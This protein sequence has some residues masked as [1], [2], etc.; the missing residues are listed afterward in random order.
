[1]NHFFMTF[2]LVQFFLFVLDIFPISGRKIM[3]NTL[4]PFSKIGAE[5]LHIIFITNNY[6]CLAKSRLYHEKIAP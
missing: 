3:H 5:G 4:V 2:I 1:M 6:I